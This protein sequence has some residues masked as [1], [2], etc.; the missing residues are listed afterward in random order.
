MKGYVACL[1]LS[2]HQPYD[3]VVVANSGK[4][5]KLQVKYATLKSNG[6]VEVRFRTSWADRHGSHIKH[7]SKEEFDY[8]AIYC[9]EKDL[10]VY[11]PNSPDCPK[12]LRFDKA[13]NNQSRYVKWAIDYLKLDGESSETIRCTPETVKT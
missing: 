9:P 3:L 13:A 4:V 11:V 12:V 7:Y 8:Y 6:I 10:V 2:E 5:F 1:P